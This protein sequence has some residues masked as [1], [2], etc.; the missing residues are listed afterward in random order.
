[1]MGTMMN[2]RSLGSY[3]VACA[4]VAAGILSAE[5]RV[6][7]APRK[8][9]AKAPRKTVTK[10]LRVDGRLRVVRGVNGR[11][12][13]LAVAKG[14]RW[15]LTGP[16]RQELLRL[17]NHRITVWGTLG[18]KKILRRSLRVNRY[19]L[20]TMNGRLPLIGRLRRPAQDSHGLVLAQ[21]KTSLPIH[22]SKAF[23][24]RLRQRL[25]CRI[26]IVGDRVDNTLKAFKFGWLSCDKPQPIK[27]KRKEKHP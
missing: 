23:L 9:E 11:E 14:K 18:P 15:S 24:S 26:W 12:V 20:V 21:K 6:V 3:V 2:R 27:P 4:L 16:Y 7:A 25:G 8:T 13:R 1:M 17:N 5:A 22:G 19:A 10:E